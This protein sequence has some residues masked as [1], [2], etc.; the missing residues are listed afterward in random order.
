MGKFVKCDVVV[1][2]FPFSDLSRSKKRPAL[3]LTDFSGD[4]ILLCQITSQPSNDIF[5][6]A[7]KSKNFVSGSLPVESFIRPLHI[8][9]ADKNIILRKV[10]KIT[11][12]LMDNVIDAIVFAL[13]Q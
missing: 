12:E 1:I 3:V 2:P 11:P 13:K 5:A 6:Q 7:L 8:F 9:T 10:G 4:D